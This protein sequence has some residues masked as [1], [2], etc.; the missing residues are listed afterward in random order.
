M[1]SNLKNDINEL[2]YKTEKDL[3]IWETNL[4]LPKGKHG[5]WGEGQTGGG[6]Q[7][8]YFGQAEVRTSMRWGD[9]KLA[10]GAM[11]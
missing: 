9:I 5:E 10:F 11:F 6:A 2:I 8:L 3:Q 7:E 4:W 1:E